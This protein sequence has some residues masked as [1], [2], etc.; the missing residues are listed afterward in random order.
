MQTIQIYFIHQTILDLYISP[1]LRLVHR[2]LLSHKQLTLNIGKTKYMILHRQRKRL[3]PC[4]EKIRIGT[5]EIERVYEIKF[6]GM[7]LDE[8]LLF[9]SHVNLVLRKVSKFA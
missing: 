5:N 6:L 2:W 4:R 8:H 3:Q 9:K 1:E 7:M